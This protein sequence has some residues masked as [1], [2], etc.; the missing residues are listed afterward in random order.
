MEILIGIVGFFVGLFA[1]SQIVFPLALV[2]PRAV[3]ARKRNVIRNTYFIK[4]LTPVFISSFIIF[5]GSYLSRELLIFS[6]PAF[7][8]GSLISF[9]M[10]LFNI[11]NNKNK[12]DMLK[13][14]PELDN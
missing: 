12:E 5:V 7:F 6:L 13:A 4:V 10:I 11:G 1:W 3:V 14:Y 2:I 9:V 8:A